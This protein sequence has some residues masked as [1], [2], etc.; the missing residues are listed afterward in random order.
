MSQC[1][2]LIHAPLLLMAVCD[3]IVLAR[4]IVVAS[5]VIANNCPVGWCGTVHCRK[6]RCQ[7]FRHAF[8]TW[9]WGRRK[10]SLN[11]GSAG[12]YAAVKGHVEMPG[13]HIAYVQFV[14]FFP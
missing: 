6:D 12:R 3:V 7:L 8:E 1:R 13:L 9:G 4:A 2:P 11:C 14:L 5:A 10:G